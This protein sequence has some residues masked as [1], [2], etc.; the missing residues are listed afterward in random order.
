M[1]AWIMCP[2]VTRIIIHSAPTLMVRLNV[3]VIL[4]FLLEV[5]PSNEINLI[6]HIFFKVI[7]R[8]LMEML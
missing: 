8:K 4:V 5:C 1:S 7:L 3:D 2:F 6:N